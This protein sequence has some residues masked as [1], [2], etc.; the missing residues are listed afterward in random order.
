MTAGFG[1]T[2]PLTTVAQARRPKDS[3]SASVSSRAI[4]P[5]PK[6]LPKLLPELQRSYIADG[7]ISTMMHGT[8]I[9]VICDTSSS[10]A[11]ITRSS[12][13]AAQAEDQIAEQVDPQPVS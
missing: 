4:Q 5:Q 1:P 6:L 10:A 9:I 3:A 13:A 8:S 7:T 12:T 11:R 2:S